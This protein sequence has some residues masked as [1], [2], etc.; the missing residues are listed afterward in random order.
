MNPKKVSSYRFSEDIVKLVKSASDLTDLSEAQVLERCVVEK[1]VEV[2]SKNVRLKHLLREPEA[3]AA[4]AKEV[5]AM[6][7]NSSKSAAQEVADQ[8]LP[9]SIEEAKKRAASKQPVEEK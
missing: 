1:V 3:I 9:Q 6:K 5:A 4:F 8:T 2:V 7:P